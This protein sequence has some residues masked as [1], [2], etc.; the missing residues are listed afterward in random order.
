MTYFD[1]NTL[2]YHDGQ[3]LEAT[4]AVTGLYSQ[5]LHYGYAVF[6]GIRAYATESGPLIFKAEAHYRRL[7]HSAARLHI[8]CKYSVEELTAITY[9]LLEK[10]KLSDA[11]I[12]PLLY[13]RMPNMGLKPSA[14]AN[15]LIVAWQWGKYLGDKLLHM[16]LSPYERPNPKA[17][18]IDA[19]ASGHYVN[20]ITASFEAQQRGFD[21]ALL[22]DAQGFVAEAP[23]AN[24]FMEK[25]GRLLTPTTDNILNGITRQ[26]IIELAQQRNIPVEECR[27]RPEEILQADSAF[28]TGTAAEIAPI[29]AFEN[30]TFPKS[31]DQSLGAVLYADFLQLVR[32]QPQMQ[33][34]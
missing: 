29:G 27:I 13:V 9:T 31:F 2:I 12:R 16:T 5:S 8:P 30:Y 3:W 18:H 34:I 20:S 19:K 10:N 14:E 25:D 33:T 22:L 11:Y 24:F 15:L 23:G 26:T 28:L 32:Q 7:Q 4:A 6:E 21:E 1:E 17:F